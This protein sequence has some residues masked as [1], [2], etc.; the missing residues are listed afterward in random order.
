M[1]EELSTGFG[2]EGYWWHCRRIE[3]HSSS[4]DSSLGLFVL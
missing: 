1:V 2:R 3:R 4:E